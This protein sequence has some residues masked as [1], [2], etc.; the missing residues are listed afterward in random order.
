MSRRRCG[1]PFEPSLRLR[2]LQRFACGV[3]FALDPLRQLAGIS[4]ISLRAG[5]FV[6]QLLDAL[7]ARGERGFL[8]GISRDSECVYRP[9]NLA[10]R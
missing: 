2:Q 3:D 9:L 5:E 7:K 6:G 10:A 8:C 4:G 1:P